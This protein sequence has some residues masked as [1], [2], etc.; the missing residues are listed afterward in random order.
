MFSCLI[1]RDKQ[2]PDLPAASRKAGTRHSHHVLG[3]GA[4]EPLPAPVGGLFRSARVVSGPIPVTRKLR[5]NPVINE[6]PKLLIFKAFEYFVEP[7][8][9]PKCGSHDSRLTLAQRCLYPR[10]R[11][12]QCRCEDSESGQRQEARFS[13]VLSICLATRLIIW[14]FFLVCVV[15]ASDLP[16]SSSAS[17]RRGLE[18]R[19]VKGNLHSDEKRFP[20][21]KKVDVVPSAPPSSGSEG[22]QQLAPEAS[23]VSGEGARERVQNESSRDIPSSIGT[24][25]PSEGADGVSSDGTNLPKDALLSTKNGSAAAGVSAVDTSGTPAQTHGSVISSSDLGR[26][27]EGIFWQQGEETSETNNG[28]PLAGSDVEVGPSSREATGSGPAFAGNKE[29][30]GPPLEDRKGPGESGQTRLDAVDSSSSTLPHGQEKNVT[31]DVAAS[32][33]LSRDESGGSSGLSRG[34][35]FSRYAGD[36]VLKRSASLDGE[37]KGEWRP[38]RH[39]GKGTGL[40]PYVGSGGNDHHDSPPSDTGAAAL[41]AP[42]L[43][44]RMC[45]KVLVHDESARLF[46]VLLLHHLEWPTFTKYRLGTAMFINNLRRKASSFD[47]HRDP[48]YAFLDWCPLHKI[49]TRGLSY[50]RTRVHRRSDL[51]MIK[52]ELMTSSREFSYSLRH[53][54]AVR[55]QVSSRT[56]LFQALLVTWDLFATSIVKFK[57]FEVEDPSALTTLGQQSRY[58]MDLAKHVLDLWFSERAFFVPLMW[59]YGSFAPVVN[60]APFRRPQQST[61]I[62]LMDGMRDYLFGERPHHQMGAGMLYTSRQLDALRWLENHVKDAVYHKLRKALRRFQGFPMVSSSSTLFDRERRSPFVSENVPFVDHFPALFR[63]KRLPTVQVTGYFLRGER[64]D[65]VK[66]GVFGDNIAD[67]RMEELMA[68]LPAHSA[69]LQLTMVD[70]WAWTR[71]DDYEDASHGDGGAQRNHTAL[72]GQSWAPCPKGSQDFAVPLGRYLPVSTASQLLNIELRW[73]PSLLNAAGRTVILLNDI[74]DLDSASVQS[75]EADPATDLDIHAVLLL[76]VQD[77]TS[78]E[79]VRRDVVRLVSCH[80]PCHLY[81]KSSQPSGILDPSRVKILGTARWVGSDQPRLLLGEFGRGISSQGVQG[82]LDLLEKGHILV[83]IS[84]TGVARAPRK[85]EDATSDKSPQ[86][87]AAADGASPGS[88]NG[89]GNGKSTP[90]DRHGVSGGGGEAGLGAHPATGWGITAKEAFRRLMRRT[91]GGPARVV[92]IQLSAEELRKAKVDKKKQR[93]GGRI[94]W[95]AV[96]ISNMCVVFFFLIIF[97]YLQWRRHVDLPWW[98]KCVCTSAA[99]WVE[100]DD[101]SEAADS[102]NPVESC[103][104]CEDSS[105][106][107][108]RSYSSAVD[109]DGFAKYRRERS[110]SIGSCGLA[111]S[112]L[113]RASRYPTAASVPRKGGSGPYDSYFQSPLSLAPFVTELSSTSAALRDFSGNVGMPLGTWSGSAY[114]SPLCMLYRTQLPH[115][116]WAMRERGSAHASFPRLPSTSLYARGGYGGRHMSTEFWWPSWNKAVRSNTAGGKIE[117][118][119]RPANTFPGSLEDGDETDD[120]GTPEQ[121]ENDLCSGAGEERLEKERAEKVKDEEGEKVETEEMEEKHGT[122]EGCDYELVVRFVDSRERRSSWV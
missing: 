92:Y 12:A 68:G 71:C 104:T 93:R 76:P 20:G 100:E 14:C 3:R 87:A 90:R 45:L 64:G 67:E 115:L 113:S 72:T 7:K 42:A 99:P 37:T 81:A 47:E 86:A 40:P 19:D 53:L 39:E 97:M 22:H 6:S 107:D 102:D 34:G 109:P 30:T 58:F 91:H 29:E 36:L 119:R 82:S 55:K 5:T 24:P 77:F 118:G 108:D 62:L 122:A 69:L 16:P 49:A 23:D 121:V 114:R 54:P 17:H 120:A 31:G 52:R 105:S 27:Q 63:D 43:Y 66:A 98:L 110:A 106:E 4:V 101:S 111:G 73:D 50:L 2:C 78:T 80:T 41:F 60:D 1:M 65:E 75:A 25:G 13:S 11:R 117:G 48:Q 21:S 32:G 46:A 35:R 56:G 85:P 112:D 10:T 74:V 83:H 59:A 70:A 94:P 96:A 57:L 33:G 84:I 95:V 38:V 51:R 89:Q 9:T 88:A 116:E 44:R 26:D 15:S 103:D 61:S 28:S 18:R 8:S 79:D